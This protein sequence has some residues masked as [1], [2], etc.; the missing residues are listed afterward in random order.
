[1]IYIATHKAFNN[2][3]LDGYIPLQVGAEIH[4]DLGYLKDNSGDNIS[5]KNPNYCEL[6]G[7]Y[8][9]W[10]NTNDDYKGL[11][12]YR[13]FFSK[14]ELSSS[15]QFFLTYAELKKYLQNADIVLPEKEFYKTT[16]KEAMISGCTTDEVYDRLRETIEEVCEDYLADFDRFFSDNNGSQYNMLFCKKE[17]FDNYCE[18]LF[19]ILF[20]LEDKIDLEKLEG[21]QKRVYGFLSERLLNIWVTHNNLKTCYVNT[22]QIE[23]PL[24]MRIR[25]IR[26]R[27]TNT[28]RFYVRNHI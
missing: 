5:G 23:L 2:P 11:V 13:R 16:A 19:K 7:L 15:P 9:I 18:W 17:V 27:I 21:Q 24:W 12:H 14:T 25:V 1:M 26:R 4:E 8:W 28:I 3:N 6:T 10:K 22:S 20:N